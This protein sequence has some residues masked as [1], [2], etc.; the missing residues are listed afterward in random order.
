MMRN[1]GQC[2]FE[3]VT[4]KAGLTDTGW[5]L[6]IGTADIDRD[7]LVDIYVANDFGTDKVYQNLGDGLFDDVS[8]S[9]IGIDTKIDS[10][11][12]S[13]KNLNSIALCF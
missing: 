4:E 2:E 9:A 8:L 10:I 11:I 6:A 5:S 3:D 13:I 12:S 1:N 7:G